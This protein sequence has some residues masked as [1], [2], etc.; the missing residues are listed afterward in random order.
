[1]YRNQGMEHIMYTNTAVEISGN[2]FDLPTSI[3]HPDCYD[4]KITSDASKLSE[5][6]AKRF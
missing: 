5:S 3:W 1:M 4:A 6:I 2:L